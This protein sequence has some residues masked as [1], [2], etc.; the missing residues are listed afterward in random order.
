[1]AQDRIDGAGPAIQETCKYGKET[2][3]MTRTRM[4]GR[5]A[6]TAAAVVMMAAASVALAHHSF[7][8]FDS[9]KE[10]ILDGTVREF[11][12]TNPHCWIQLRVI[13]NGQPVEYSIESPSPNQLSR[14]GW[15]STSL[16]A[17]DRAKITIQPLRDGS[18]GGS[19]VRG[20]LANGATLTL[21][22]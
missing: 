1:M 4:F 3:F 11:R 9:S 5:S 18:K 13:E 19:F 8:M 10:T 20:V 14:A 15:T 6:A 2:G 21:A 12:W 16:K 22:N 7:S 17:G